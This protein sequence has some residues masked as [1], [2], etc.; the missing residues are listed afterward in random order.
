MV[1]R[2]KENNLLDG[3]DDVDNLR[4]IMLS[5]HLVKCLST[6]HC[7]SSSTSGLNAYICKMI[8]SETII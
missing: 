3:I 7:A 6:K 8:Y 2:F 5:G 1:E 4:T